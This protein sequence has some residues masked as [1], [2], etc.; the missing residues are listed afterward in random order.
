VDIYILSTLAVG[1]SSFGLGYSFRRINL[2]WQNQALEAQRE[3]KLRAG[4]LQATVSA[5]LDGIIVID[6]DGMVVDFSEAAERIFGYAR[7]TV[8]GKNMAELIVPPRY[9]EAHN[10]GMKRMRETG[11]QKI[12]GQRI[13]IEAMRSDGS[14]FMSE[15]AISQSVSDE[16]E[17]FIAYIRD[18]SDA[19]AAQQALIEAKD[20]A[21]AANEAKSRFLATM[22]HEIRTPFNAVLGLLEILSETK[23][24]SEQLSLIKTAENSSLALLR[25]INDVLDYARMSAGQS[26]LVHNPFEVGSAFDDV[27]HL[28][29]RQAEDKGLNLTLIKDEVTPGLHVSGDLGRIRQ[30][31]LNFVSNAIKFTDEGGIKLEIKSEDL[32]NGNQKLSFLV[33]D[34]GIGISEEARVKLFDEFFMADNTDSREFEGTGLGLTISKGLAELMNGDIGCSS[35]LTEG[36]TFWVTLELPET[37]AGDIKPRYDA[38]PF[39]IGNCRILLAEDNP[40]NRLVVKHVL[41][42]KCAKLVM[43]ENGEE[44]LSVLEDNEFDLIL[45]DIFMPVMSG[46]D[47]TRLIRSSNNKHKD[48]PIIALTAMGNFHDLDSLKTIGV[49]EIVTKPFKKINLLT[50]IGSVLGSSD[51]L[52]VPDQETTPIEIEQDSFLSELDADELQIFKDQLHIDL[53]AIAVD[54][55]ASV[56]ENDPQKALRPTHTLKGL[57]GT[58]GMIEL[59]EL[60]QSTHETIKSTDNQ[61]SEKKIKETLDLTHLYLGQL[62]DLFERLKQAA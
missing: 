52:V 40:T 18:I 14:E 25:I 26:K 29:G 22:S 13:E 45:M 12:L 61:N 62:D 27:I 37:S 20:A 21:E 19:K 50:A 31:L 8:I 11:Q 28:F 51:D 38:K 56:K 59:S 55:T 10:A 42:K 17:I 24:N 49:D 44:V 43:V 32:K 35:K 33:H 9:R 60:A 36:T 16:G 23:L 5:S 53:T 2:H 39:D 54:M 57:A 47:A 58:Y 7:R 34:T 4:Q 3:A 15:L 46:K 6:S 41:E 48:I 30:I 1:A